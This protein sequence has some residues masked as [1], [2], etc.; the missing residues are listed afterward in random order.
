M[1]RILSLLPS[2]TEIV[3]ALGLAHRLVG[4]SHECEIPETACALPVATEPKVDLDARSRDL[5][6]QVR[7][8]VRDGLSVYQ[9]DADL[10]R[11]LRPDVILTQTQCEVC[12][13]TPGDLRSALDAWVD[14]ETALVAVEPN[15]LT[16][17]LDDFARVGR[18]CGAAERGAA[19]RERER[20]RVD[21]IAGEANAISERP[22]VACLEWI[23]PLMGC[24]NWLPELVEHA[25]GVSIMGDAGQHAAWSSLEALAALDPDVV[26]VAPCGFGLARTREELLHVA[27][28][29]GWRAAFRGL[30][31]VREGRCA[32]IDGHLH[33]NRPGPRIAESLEIVVEILQPERFDFGW[34]RSG[35]RPLANDDLTRAKDLAYST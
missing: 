9:V 21:A 24:G 12:A 7:A 25:G 18:G 17:V 5:D 19:L 8:L 3:G 32:L 15:R 1:E 26:L 6:G 20:A 29:P 33:M 27:A 10:V 13:V 11:S 22:R 14:R 31:A 30:R 34:R 35:W 4:R 16:D 2:T 28:D 23:D